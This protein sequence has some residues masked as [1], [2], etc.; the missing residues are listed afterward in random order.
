MT[1]GTPLFHAMNI[2]AF[3]RLDNQ[4]STLQNEISSG[5]NDPLPSA[6]TVRALRLSAA[7]EHKSSLDRFEQNLDRAASR[8]DTT[9]TA[10]ADVVDGM[11][12]LGALAVRGG[13]DISVEERA[14]LRAEAIQIKEM[15]VDFANT[16]DS[17]GRPL[18]GG[19][20]PKGDAFV[21]TPDG[22]V[23][24][25]DGGQHRLRVSEST[26]IET[27]I[28]GEQAF[29]TVPDGRGGKASLFTMIDGFLRTLDSD[30]DI[31][32]PE[33]THEGGLEF[34]PALTRDLRDW[35]MT[36]TGPQGSVD[37]SLELSA[38]APD[39][40]V[41]A[42]NARQSDTGVTAT[43]GPG[44]RSVMLAGAGDV[45]LSDLSV[46]PEFS[47]PVARIT[48]SDGTITKL[49]ENHKT[50]DAQVSLIGNASNHFA[51]LRARVGAMNASVVERQDGLLD[52]QQVADSMLA[53]L[54]DLAVAKAITTLQQLMVTRQVS[55]QAYIKIGQTNLFDYLR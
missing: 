25:G 4:I 10:L 34:S 5:K 3:S 27:G 36:V 23:Y 21:N 6:D 30:G 16:R 24:A 37:L 28:N 54:Q 29:M 44:G 2:R 8:L 7:T 17:T 48:G 11:Q 15:I 42:I 35:S 31:L 22:V 53:N 51:D 50:M 26:R 43:L 12:R 33:V 52:R 13:S 32:K 55:Q 20:M 45:S 49:V 46:S 41:D 1:I 40:L 9:D 47:G 14:S 38:G 18:F 19:H 39:A